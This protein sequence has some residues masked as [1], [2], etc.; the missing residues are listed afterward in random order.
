MLWHN[1]AKALSL[2]QIKADWQRCC[3]CV[4]FHEPSQVLGCKSLSKVIVNKL[5]VFSWWWT[6]YVEL[7]VP[8]N[9]KLSNFHI[10][11]ETWIKWLLSLMALY[12]NS[13][14]RLLLHVQCL[15]CFIV[16]SSFRNNFF[17]PADSSPQNNSRRHEQCGEHRSLVTTTSCV[18]NILFPDR[19]QGSQPDQICGKWQCIKLSFLCLLISISLS[20][21]FNLGSVEGDKPPLPLV[22]VGGGV[23]WGVV[24]STWLLIAMPLCHSS[25]AIISVKQSPTPPPLPP[26]PWMSCSQNKNK[27]KQDS[28]KLLCMTV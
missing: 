21:S 23:G 22:G 24:V 4:P 15:S 11:I 18:S 14:A 28:S 26:P 19:V 6:L 3:C 13:E 20:T 27:V 12:K 25:P 9:Q 1:T 17:E 10:V 8:H 7:S 5:E 16:I 2:W